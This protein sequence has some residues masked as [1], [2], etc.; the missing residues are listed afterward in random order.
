MRIDY[1]KSLPNPKNK[2]VMVGDSLIERGYWNELVDNSKV[3]NR[4]ISGITIRGLLKSRLVESLDQSNEIILL[5][6]INDI[7]QNRDELDIQTD[8][9]TLFTLL[10]KKNFKKVSIIGLLPAFDK[11]L[12][13]RD[14]MR[15]RVN[16]LIGQSRFHYIDLEETLNHSKF[17][18]DGVHLNG[19][20]YK[21]L[22]SKVFK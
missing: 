19:H 12:A 4:G 14:L 20:G 9:K 16:K 15:K 8:L 1:F 17:F 22:V 18:M 3:I 5:I 11:E 10:N 7:W 6:G 13:E 21:T 2:I